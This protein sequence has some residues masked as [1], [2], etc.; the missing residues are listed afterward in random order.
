M[1][2]PHGHNLGSSYGEHLENTGGNLWFLFCH[3]QKGE[4]PNLK[5]YQLPVSSILAIPMALAKLAVVDW[6][7][8]RY[9]KV[10]TS[11]SVNVTLLGK[12]LFEDVIKRLRRGRIFVDGRGGSELESAS[13]LAATERPGESERRDLARARRT[14]QCAAGTWTLVMSRELLRLRLSHE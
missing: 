11:V 6:S 10:L 5:S 1:L 3:E 13:Q 7:P 12:W 4:R 9:A 2:L 14:P 8:E